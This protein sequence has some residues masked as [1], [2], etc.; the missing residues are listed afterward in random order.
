[1]A[2][3][4]FSKQKMPALVATARSTWANSR[5]VKDLEYLPDDYA[6]QRI[7]SE[8]TAEL[9]PVLN[10]ERPCEKFTINWL[11]TSDT[12]ATL[13]TGQDNLQYALCDVTGEQ[14]EADNA[15]YKITKS[16]KYAVEIVDDD[17]GDTYNTNS[18]VSLALLTLQK[19]IWEKAAVSVLTFINT[20]AGENK[21]NNSS[22]NM[23]PG[24]APTVSGDFDT[25]LPLDSLDAKV[26]VPYLRHVAK[27]NKFESPYVIDG[28]LLASQIIVNDAE[29]GT[30]A[31]D[32]GK[33]RLW[34]SVGYELDTTNMIDAGFHDK[35]FM[36]DK[37]AVAFASAAFAPEAN[38]AQERSN[39]KL[40][41]KMPIFG[42]TFSGRPVE[43]DVLYKMTEVPIANGSNRCKL[44]HTFGGE[45]KW[46]IWRGPKRA[47]DPVT[48]VLSFQLES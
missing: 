17:C 5:A 36:L 28:L 8:Q 27:F 44:V 34:R 29:D 7:I 38:N 41:F 46:D 18:K 15:E 37:G 43:M 45:L 13:A 40:S 4:D 10:G 31:G 24:I 12:P 11:Q 47:A 39:G 3:G 19:K 20:F 30:N 35:M 21:A 9:T 26:L 2:L 14:L 42:K 22:F 23:A 1:M 32:V 33:M 25:Y 48:G 6:L 16:I